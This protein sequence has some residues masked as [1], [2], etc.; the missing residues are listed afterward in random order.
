M[1][2]T[3]AYVNAMS[4]NVTCLTS[5][6]AGLEMTEQ[7]KPS[8]RKTWMRDLNT[9]PTEKDSLFIQTTQLLSHELRKRMQ[10]NT[11]VWKVDSAT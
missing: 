4:T 1:Q 9:I 11:D 10:F 3:V 2:I 5:M 6:L 7:L 8:E